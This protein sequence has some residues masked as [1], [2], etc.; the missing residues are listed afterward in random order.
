[1][2]VTKFQ[3]ISGNQPE[4]QACSVSQLLHMQ[5]GEEKIKRINDNI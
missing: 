2:P 4:M 1:M 3:H 5:G